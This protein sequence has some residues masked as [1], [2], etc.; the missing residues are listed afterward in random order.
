MINDETVFE[1]YGFANGGGVAPQFLEPVFFAGDELYIQSCQN[2]TQPDIVTGFII[3][4]DD[5]EVLECNT[6][7]TIVEGGGR[8]YAVRDVGDRIICG[9]REYVSKY[10]LQNLNSYIDYPYFF[11]DSCSF[12]G[13][14]MAELSLLST[15]EDLLESSAFSNSVKR[16]CD[17]EYKERYAKASSEASQLKDKKSDYFY[18]FFHDFEKNNEKNIFSR[19]LDFAAY[20]SPRLAKQSKWRHIDE[21]YLAFFDNNEKECINNLPSFCLSAL[22]I[23]NNKAF[24]ALIEGV[25]EKEYTGKEIKNYTR[26]IPNV[27]YLKVKKNVETTYSIYNCRSHSDKGIE[28]YDIIDDILHAV[29]INKINVGDLT[30]LTFFLKLVV[31][32]MIKIID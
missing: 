30:M 20:D 4:T 12:T 24:D 29:S 31:K 13:K 1:L 9:E 6:D 14:R 2:K 18:L 17:F 23:S 8:F 10:L 26:S 11:K 21:R 5:V 28:V 25:L 22:T 15:H 27:N 16:F 7:E 3:F 32:K 19:W